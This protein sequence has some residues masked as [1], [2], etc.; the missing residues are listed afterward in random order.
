M[1]NFSGSLQ[2]WDNLEFFTDFFLNEVNFCPLYVQYSLPLTVIKS[3]P[4][5]Q[6]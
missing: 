6:L 4:A 3:F 1:S 5:Y 2:T